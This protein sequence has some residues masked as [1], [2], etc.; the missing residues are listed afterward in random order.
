[1][2]RACPPAPA[3][4]SWGHREAPALV[5]GGPLPPT[6]AGLGFC[7]ATFHIFTLFF[8]TPLCPHCALSFCK[9]CFPPGATSVAAGLS[10]VL[11]LGCW[12]WL[13]PALDG[14]G[15]P[16]RGPPC[17]PPPAP[18]HPHPV[19]PRLPAPAWLFLRPCPSAAE[20]GEAMPTTMAVPHGVVGFSGK[21]SKS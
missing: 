3:G 12:S 20:V 1:M 14:P 4:L 15:L 9:K 17:S 10:C 6:S 19:Q 18:R 7:K 2:F 8:L 5:P 11:R 21:C 13:C 16:S